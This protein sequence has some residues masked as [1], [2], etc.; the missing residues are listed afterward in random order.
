MELINFKKIK[1]KKNKIKKNLTLE[2][3]LIWDF[4][5][6]RKLCNI[7]FKKETLIGKYILNFYS[8][9]VEFGIEIDNNTHTKKYI[10]TKDEYMQSMGIT[11]IKFSNSEI[12]NDLEDTL[13]NIKESIINIKY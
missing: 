5:K 3:K 7:K 8:P 9:E 13:K 12:K 6:E 4:I 10:L 2:E 11:V 1:S